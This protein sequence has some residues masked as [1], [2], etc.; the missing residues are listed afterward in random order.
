MVDSLS[1]VRQEAH[2][3]DATLEAFEENR[4]GFITSVIDQSNSVKPTGEKAERVKVQGMKMMEE[5]VKAVQNNRS[6]KQHYLDMMLKTGPTETIYVAPRI[7]KING[8]D[9]IL[10]VIINVG[11]RKY[12]LQ[13]GEN[14]GV[15]QLVAEEYRNRVVGERELEARKVAYKSNNDQFKVESVMKEIDREF[16]T[17]HESAL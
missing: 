6:A 1:K 11:R 14:K 17:S 2:D 8:I 4:M 9:T 12:A 5:A 13:P 15:P 7:M 16:G 10:P 3:R